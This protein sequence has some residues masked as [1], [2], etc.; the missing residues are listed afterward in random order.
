[1]VDA[2][3]KTLS[4]PITVAFTNLGSKLMKPTAKKE[5]CIDHVKRYV[6]LEKVAKQLKSIGKLMEVISACYY[7]VQVSIMDKYHPALV[8]VMIDGNFFLYI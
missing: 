1:M 2:A 3:I 4:N 8:K 6:G 5:K 7:F